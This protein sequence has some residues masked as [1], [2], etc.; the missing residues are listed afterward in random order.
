MELSK[1]TT[2]AQNIE[3]YSPEFPFKGIDGVDTDRAFR[4]LLL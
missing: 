4:L 1:S 3:I 2:A